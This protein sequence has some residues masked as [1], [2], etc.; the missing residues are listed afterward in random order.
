MPARMEGN[1]VWNP[2]TPGSHHG[3]D[4][5]CR[6]DSL[7]MNKIVIIAKDV[8]IN[9]RRKIIITLPR[10]GAAAEYCESF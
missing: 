4:W 5:R 8:L 6:V 9:C 2:L 7:T 1:H 3:K 10:V